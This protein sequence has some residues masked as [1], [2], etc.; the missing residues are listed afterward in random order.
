[1]VTRWQH[2]DILRADG[3]GHSVALAQPAWQRRD[4]NDA[5]PQAQVAVIQHL[6]LQQ[7]ALAYEAGHESISRPS[8][9]FRRRSDLLHGPV[10]DVRAGQRSAVAGCRQYSPPR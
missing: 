7:I 9:D 10:R 3:Q 6:R 5:A 1:P 8:I 4:V 2:A